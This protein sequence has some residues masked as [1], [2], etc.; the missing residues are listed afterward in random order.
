MNVFQKAGL[1]VV[2]L[3]P[4]LSMAAVDAGVTTAIESAKTDGLAVAGALLTTAV[5]IW[6]ALYIKR[7]FFG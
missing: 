6:G 3:V 1:A 5:A 4:T 7:K 2:A